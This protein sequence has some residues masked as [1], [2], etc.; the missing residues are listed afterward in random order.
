M[1][2]Y[3]YQATHVTIL[4]CVLINNYLFIVRTVCP[5]L[6]SPP[7]LPPSLSLSLSLALFETKTVHMEGY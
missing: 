6:P 3:I 2:W 5:L 1:S 7:P 4:L